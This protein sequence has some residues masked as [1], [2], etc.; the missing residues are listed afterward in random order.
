MP[1]ATLRVKGV[2]TNQTPVLNEA[3]I[4][5]C[6]LIRYKPDQGAVLVEKI[7]GWQKFFANNMVTVPRAL[8]AWRDTQSVS[9][10]AVGTQ[11]RPTTFLSQ[12]SVISNGAQSD[13]TPRSSTDNISPALASISGNSII[14][15]T[16]AT[17]PNVTNYDAVYIPAHISI[18]GVVLFGLYQTDPD[19]HS[20]VS[21]YTVQATDALGAPL[22][23]PSSSTSPTVAEFTTI[24]GQVLVTVT[25]AAHGYVIGDTYPVLIS[26]TVGGAT[27]YGNYPIVSITDADNFVITSS[28][29]PTASTT[30]FINGGNARYIYS[31]GVGSIS[32][33]TG[34]G[35]GG[36]GRGGYGSGTAIIPSTGTAISAK[37]YTLDNWGEILVACPVTVPKTATEVPFSPIYIWAAEQGAPT[38]TIIPEAPPV[39]D[40]MFVAMPER[41]IIAWGSTFTG[42]QDPLLIRWCDINNFY[43]WIGEVTNQAGSYRLPRGSRIVGG[44]QGPQQGIIWTDLGCWTM[45]YINQPLVYGF[46]EV[47]TGCGLIGRKAAG[48]IGGEV[49]WMGP[50]QFFILGDGGPAPLPCPI[51][52]VV[53][54][55]IDKTNA[56]K[57]RVAVNSLFN[58]IAWYYPTLSSGGEVAAYVKYNTVLQMWDFG[59][60]ARSAWIDQTVLGAPIGADP[61]S[62]YLYQHETSPDADG[63]A[64][65]ASFQ[66]GYM[67]MG[68][69]GEGDMLTFVDQFWP[70]MKFG[71]YGGMQNAT[72][73]LTFYAANYPG[74][75]PT[76]FGPYSFTQ[77]TKFVTPRL[78][79][80]LVAIEVS[81][82]D[83]GSWW[84]VGGIRY[85]YMSDGKF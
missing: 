62:L 59:A 29:T 28:T 12:L 74:D 1:H 77:T 58:E 85:R 75:T 69:G 21:T 44:I 10:L 55:D 13:I 47:G 48:V 20:G 82:S 30:G 76:A 14:T 31:F 68:D 72:L 65:M 34:Y 83:V 19:G 11:N 17:T 43:S 84:R 18:G 40:G 54:Q 9:Y 52:D 56:D 53:F 63:Q 23:A 3:G 38:A 45:Q 32:A 66:T 71:Y 73:N 57:I 4:S 22:P 16:D 80:R 26:T 70:D 67:V 81:S 41:Q 7:G 42:I 8:W 25:L 24:S 49:Y 39:N 15:I 27:F 50:S 37:D 78:R 79:K 36:Y 2:D 64:L 46:Q 5:S 35:I 61:N 6:Q 51:W 60:L 33:G